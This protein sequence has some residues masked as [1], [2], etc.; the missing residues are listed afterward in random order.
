MLL[1]E[2]SG[3]V[4]RLPM[5]LQAKTLLHFGKCKRCKPP[6]RSWPGVRRCDFADLEVYESGYQGLRLLPTS[7]NAL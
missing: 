7:L 1:L 2:F 3:V 5:L 4:A 6:P